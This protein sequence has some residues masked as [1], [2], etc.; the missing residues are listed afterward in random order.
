MNML[1]SEFD[2]NLPENLI[3]QKP[4]EK[5]EN[6]RLLAVN[7]GEKSLADEQFSNFPKFL[8]K[9]DVIVLNNTKVFPARI[10]GETETG[11]E[12]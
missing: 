4:L 5:R 9:G 8:K 12:S 1:I 3:A 6:S 7:R 2:Y 11:R 10:F